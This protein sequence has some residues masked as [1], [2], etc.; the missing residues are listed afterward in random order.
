MA[1]TS[2]EPVRP[3]MRNSDGCAMD[4]AYR[5]TASTRNRLRQA[6][7]NVRHR[8]WAQLSKAESN[9]VINACRSA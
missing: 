4:A 8:H 7:S 6:L 1:Q 9:E 5:T 2:D 3:F